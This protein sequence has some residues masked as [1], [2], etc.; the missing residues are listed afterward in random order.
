M[1]DFEFNVEG[2]EITISFSA[3]A[4]KRLKERQ[5]KS[6]QVSGAVVMLGEEILE[7]KN[8]HEFIIIDEDLFE[9]Y[10]FAVHAERSGDIIIDVITVVDTPD[11]W[12][13]RGTQVLRYKGGK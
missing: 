5:V 4:Q 1:K 2:I 6:Y 9:S 7:M 13:R 11:I 8:G 10:V 3:H 12:N